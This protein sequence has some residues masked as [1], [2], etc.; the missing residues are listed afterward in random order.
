MLMTIK[1]ENYIAKKYMQG[2]IKLPNT[3]EPY[4]SPEEPVLQIKRNLFVPILPF[5]RFQIF[6]TDECILL[7][8]SYIIHFL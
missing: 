3:S 7:T 4:S 6:C 1:I 5:L 2:K 8:L